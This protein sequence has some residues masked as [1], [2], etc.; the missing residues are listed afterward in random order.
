M[1]EPVRHRFHS[2]VF[3]QVQKRPQFVLIKAMRHC[4]LKRR[5]RYPAGTA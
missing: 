4:M 2:V 5:C 1:A 3:Q